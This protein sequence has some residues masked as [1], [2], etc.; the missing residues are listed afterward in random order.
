MQTEKVTPL[1]DNSVAQGQACRVAVGREAPHRY[2]GHSD[3]RMQ[4]L[5]TLNSALSRGDVSTV[6]DIMNGDCRFLPSINVEPPASGYTRN[7]LC[8]TPQFALMA[9]VWA[10]GAR[11]PIHAHA[12]SRCWVRV[13]RGS[14]TETL[15]SLKGRARGQLELARMSQDALSAGSSSYV[16]DGLGVHDMQNETTPAK[17]GEVAVSLHLYA[18]P[19]DSCEVYHRVNGRVAVSQAPLTFHSVLGLPNTM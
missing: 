11:S 16:D 9:L 12:G 13:L 8:R 19:F 2:D 1:E 4:P 6:T 18:P 10:P 5:M 3:P 7:L 14:L 17:R 15:Y